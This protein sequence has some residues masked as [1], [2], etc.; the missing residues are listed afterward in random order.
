M[1]LAVTTALDAMQAPTDG[2]RD[3]C[4]LPAQENAGRTGV[5]EEIMT[6]RRFT[7]PAGWRL[8][9]IL[10]LVA[11]VAVTPA[12]AQVST[13]NLE[14]QVADDQG[15]LLPGVTVTATLAATG[16]QQVGVSESNGIALLEALP[17][18][19][20]TVRIELSGFNPV[21]EDGIVL[22]VGQTAKVSA[23]LQPIVTEELTVTAEAPLVDVHKMDSSTNITP[24]QI[25]M[26][27]VPDRD[28]QRLAFIAPGVQRERGAFRFISGGPVIGASGNASQSTILVDGVDLTD[29]ALGLARTRFS[30][31]A[32]R[33]FRVIN[34]RFDTEIG[35]SAGGALTI[36]TRNGT[37]D[38]AG[39]AFAFYR[40]DELR[41]A[42][43]LEQENLPYKRGQYG[44]TLGGPIVRDRTHY[45]ASLEYINED[46]VSL[47]RPGGE[48]ASLADDISHPFD[49]TLGLVSMTHSISA[50]QRLAGKLVYERYREDNFRVGGV[51]DESNG[52]SLNRDNW[53]LTAEHVL[54]PSSSY[55]NELRVQFG[56]R[57]YSEPPNTQGVLTEWFSGGA[58]LQTG[59]NY[60]GHLLG[61]GDVWE[62]RDTAHMYKGNHAIKT[63]LSAQ[64]ISETYRQDT[65]ATGLMIYLTDDRS[66]P[67]AYS[68]GVGSSEIDKSTTLYGAF[69]Q[70]DW[71]VNPNL[72]LSYGIRYDLDTDGNNPD[73]KHPLVGSRS[74]DTDNWQPRLGFSWDV[75]GD[76]SR[77]LRGG[78]GRFTGRYL[79]VPA[80][81]ELQQN[82]VTGRPL[83]TRVN[84]ALYGL[85]PAFWLDPN[86]PTT[87]GLLLAPQIALLSDDLEAPEAD[88]ITLGYTHRLGNTNLFFDVEGIY[89]EGDNEIIVR[90]MN[91][92]GNPL[93]RPNLAY[94]QINMYTNEGYSKY[95][96]LV[97][98]LNGTIKGGHLITASVTLGD[99]KNVSDD[100][101]PAFPYGYPS[102]P[103]DIDAEYGRSRNDERFRFVTSAIFHLPW[104]LTVAPIYEY[105]SGQPWTH[106]I[107]YDYNGDGKA[108]DR[109]E[110]VDRNDMDGPPFRQVSV[111]I[112]KAF[113]VA[114]AGQ[115]DLIV[116]AF[117]LFNTVNYNVASVDGAEFL[118][119]PTVANPTIAAV[120]NPN[121]GKYTTTFPGREIQLGLR[122]TF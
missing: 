113:E 90:D 62:I 35:Q 11:M 16:L 8:A 80:F 58:T 54:I 7:I 75:G 30:Q 65:F 37:N 19:T 53:N 59:T 99:K 110:G 26:L 46:N 111:R 115:V 28:F 57:K 91:F 29:G 31:D 39:S 49:Q 88:Q 68:Y 17:P 44:F 6:T 71:R 119:G 109:P 117:N 114:G 78:A 121:Y 25:E 85:P 41:E 13:A 118:R 10:A 33:E 87:T 116:E 70:D 72:T 106:R 14:I 94:D 97:F 105:G 74:R 112:T 21:V 84:G 4:V 48:Y 120:P 98:S 86:N 122:Y 76:G 79:L 50:E 5:R 108:S 36:V 24:Q 82:G 107:G 73:F 67:V 66:I 95:K 102:D 64:H 55:L 56:R 40:A 101:S 103:T 51:A 3:G 20:Y 93:A 15:T 12:L 69:L 60:L 63:G 42:G 18:G 32:I 96:A 52:Q 34:N 100:F 23:T 2:A 45:F 38:L 61:E 9:T 89:V 77:V 104:G 1:P 92:D 22:R 43:A 83:F 27:P 47:F 81:V